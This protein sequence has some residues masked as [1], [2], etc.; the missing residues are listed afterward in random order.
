MSN[1]KMDYLTPIEAYTQSI[2][3]KEVAAASF[4]NDVLHLAQTGQKQGA[5]ATAK[6]KQSHVDEFRRKFDALKLKQHDDAKASRMAYAELVMLYGIKKL[7]P[8]NKKE[9]KQ[10]L[11]DFHASYMRGFSIP[12]EQM[13]KG[14]FDEILQEGR[15]PNGF[16]ETAHILR[17]PFTGTTIGG[18]NNTL[19]PENN[20]AILFYAFI[21]PQFRGFGLSRKIVE[22]VKADVKAAVADYTASNGVPKYSG[23]PLLLIEALPVT[24]MTIKD[25]FLDT[26][27][28]P[29][30]GKPPRQGDDFSKSGAMVETE[31][32]RVW[33]KLGGFKL[34]G[35]TYW[36]PSL[37]EITSVS[38]KNR[39]DVAAYLNDDPSL[40]KEQRAAAKKTLNKAIGNGEGGY[41]YD[42]V[43][44]VESGQTTVN[45]EQVRRTTEQAY[46]QDTFCYFSKADE[47]LA[48][49]DPYALAGTD[50]YFQA[51]RRSLAKNMDAEGNI[52]LVPI[53]PAVPSGSE[54]TFAA[55]AKY[56]EQAVAA[57][58]NW[59]DLKKQTKPYG[60]FLKRLGCNIAAAHKKKVAMDLKM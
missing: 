43:A 24:D 48:K 46:A 10:D 32:D 22:K 15:R 57:C 20:S 56:I 36:S 11:R 26:T 2:R 58:H 60:E 59:A 35:V 1:N 13:S 45:A 41:R 44:L 5:F 4:Q 21:D 34:S 9:Y 8:E 33:G 25:I 49:K 17:C 55:A 51:N 27:G 38:G 19:Q 18:F 30:D 29:A 40:T 28:I 23:D 54:A 47:K 14:E 3:H 16:N 31:R 12:E 37:R 53:T 39:E 7:E 50:I 42:L 52:K 6:F